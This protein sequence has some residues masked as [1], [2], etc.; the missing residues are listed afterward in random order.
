M[1]R[2]KKRGPCPCGSGIGYPN[3]CGR[4]IDEGELPGTPAEFMCSRYTAYAVGE[5][6]YVIGTTD[7]EGSAWH[8]DEAAWREDIREFGRRCDFLGVSVLSEEVDG[9]VATV[10]FR[11]QLRRGRED[12]SFEE[13]SRF[14]RRDGRWL[15]SSGLLE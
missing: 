7:S 14:V 15:Y 2:R 11:A 3:C 13:T 10:R 8:P 12:A 5:V 4:F 6:D 1:A 9:D